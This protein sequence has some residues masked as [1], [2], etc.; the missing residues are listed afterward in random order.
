MLGNLSRFNAAP[1]WVFSR[2][3]APLAFA[4][5]LHFARSAHR[6]RGCAP[7]PA[8]R[9]GPSPGEVAA[10]A[11]ANR[12]KGAPMP[13]AQNSDEPLTERGRAPSAKQL[14]YLRSLAMQR[15]ESFA[16][17]QT[18]SQASAEINRLRS[19]RPGSYVERQVEREG[20]SRDMAGRGGDSAVRDSEIVGYGSSA[21]WR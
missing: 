5:S 9:N 12:A 2:G 4:T 19:R 15:G 1:R 11:K 14:R 16:Y 3:A 18:A 13:T 8:V 17:P 7:F 20:V 6:A 21:R 10:Q